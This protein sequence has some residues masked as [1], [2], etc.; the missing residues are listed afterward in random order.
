MHKIRQIS[1]EEFESVL[2]DLMELLRD[3]VANDASVGF[4][5]PV[6][7]EVNESFWREVH[8]VI[9]NR[10]RVLLVSYDGQDKV[11]GTIQLDLATRPNALHRGEV[12]K[13]LVHT[14]HR[15]Q[16]IAKALIDAVEECA[17]QLNRTLLVLDT[18]QGSDAERLYG[19]WG[20][21]R[22]GVIPEYARVND[23][24]LQATVVF[25]KL[26]GNEKKAGTGN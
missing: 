22:V 23:N 3:A 8:Q 6:A 5:H 26:L 11:T 16:G 14:T 7:P 21:V 19:K 20:Y 24:S 12:Q 10:N 25:Y 15:R 1:E 18:F 17:R 2:P 13:L 4:L 9:E